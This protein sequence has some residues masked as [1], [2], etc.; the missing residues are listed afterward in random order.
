MYIYIY[1]VSKKK[2]VSM[3]NYL[4]IIHLNG[5]LHP[6]SWPRHR[7][8]QHLGCSRDVRGRGLLMERLGVHG[9]VQ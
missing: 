6:A 3:E 1:I 2:N 4:V 5:P 7:L 9:V 8:R